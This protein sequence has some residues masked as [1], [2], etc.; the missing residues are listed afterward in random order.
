MDDSAPAP[1]PTPTSAGSP[2]E[3]GRRAPFDL[4]GGHLALDLANTVADRGGEQP[5]DR[6]GRY[7]DLLAWAVQAEVLGAGAAAALGRRAGERPAEA[8]AALAAAGELREALFTVFAAVATGSE[9]PAAELVT[10]N[11]A[12]ARALPHLRVAVAAGGD[13]FEWG[14]S[15]RGADLEAPLW[16]VVR[17]A[18]ELL[19]SGERE[20]VRECDSASCRWLFLDRS[21]NR[22]RRWCDMK[23]CG[24]RVKA[25]RHYRR[26]K[27]AAG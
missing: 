8:G 23:T 10:L 5:E 6:L 21:R 7:D 16:P 27:K 18:A 17:A 19:V 11:R 2:I 1:T 13:G 20:L 14:W 9:P 3:T 22:S 4:S 15:G 12:L 26:R 25:R 24:N